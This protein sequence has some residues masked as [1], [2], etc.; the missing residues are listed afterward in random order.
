MRPLI[1]ILED[2]RTLEHKLDSIYRY[3][4][5]TDD[6]V[7]IDILKVKQAVVE[8]DLKKVRNEIKEYL[9]E[10]IGDDE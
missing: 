3:M 10:L 9:V 5:R 1:E 4:V 6:C 2:E 7:S 8:K